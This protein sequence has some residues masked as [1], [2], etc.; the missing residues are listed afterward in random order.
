MNVSDIAA[1][2]RIRAAAASATVV[3]TMREITVT[4]KTSND[5]GKEDRS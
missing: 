4:T 1:A 3:A 2:V 5:Y